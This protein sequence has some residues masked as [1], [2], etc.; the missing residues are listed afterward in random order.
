MAIGAIVSVAVDAFVTTQINHQDYSWERAGVALAA[1]ALSGAIG[2]AVIAPLAA[3]AGVTAGSL[4]AV[5]V[6]ATAAVRTGTQLVVGAGLAAGANIFIASGQRTANQ[7]LE[8]EEVSI[9]TYRS[10]IRENIT[11]DAV[12]GAAGYVAGQTLSSAIKYSFPIIPNGLNS[13]SG[14]RIVIGGAQAVV[15]AVSNSSLMDGAFSTLRRS[16][17]AID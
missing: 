8:G 6:A 11:T 15:Q 10:N 7:A 1:G 14:Q 16:Q 9:E 4:Y 12:F 5:P 13:N 2:A 3:A 17:Q